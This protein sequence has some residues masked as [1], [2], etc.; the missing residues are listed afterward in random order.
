MNELAKEDLEQLYPVFR[1]QTLELLDQMSDDLLAVEA[2]IVD[3]EIV[4]RLRRCA[5]TIKGD[6]ACIGLE[7]MSNVA[8]GAEDYLDGLGGDASKLDKQIVGKLLGLVDVIRGAMSN[9]CPTDLHLDSR[10]EASRWDLESEPGSKSFKQESA[11]GLKA[12]GKRRKR[13]I[14]VDASKVD[15]LLNLA[16]EMMIAR[17][18]L[19]Q[20]RRDVGGNS[21]DDL[22]LRRMGE[23]VDCLGGLI[24]QFQKSALKMRMVPVDTLFRRYGRAMR[25][26]AGELGK[27]VELRYSGE[28]TELDRHLVEMLYEPVLHLLRNAIDHGIEPVNERVRAGKN[29]AGLILMRA[30]HEGEEVV[31]EVSDDGRGIDL[32]GLKR[33]AQASGLLAESNGQD[34]SDEESAKLVFADGVSTADSITVLSGRGIGGAA[35]KSMVDQ[36]RG[37]VTLKTVRGKGT[38]FTLRVPS[39]LAILRSLLFSSGAHLF[40][41]PMAAVR[42]VAKTDEK[43][44]V[45]INGVECYRIHGRLLSLVKVSDKNEFDHVIVVNAGVREYAI[46]TGEVRGVVELVVKPIEGR[47]TQGRPY[48]GAAVLGDGQVVLIQ[49]ARA[50]YERALNKESSKGNYGDEHGG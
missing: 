12:E 7:R 29:P 37:T 33:R 45:I 11:A 46:A 3:N 50:L 10:Y 49:D 39:T 32:A 25:E 26:L 9:E 34:L 35:V 28:K 18:S 4:A 1:D 13:V 48:I 14:R 38:T 24:T 23:S 47:W 41:L 8:H 36:V 44:V 27:R 15:D 2:G 30:F 5:H 21:A 42:E 19:E 22:M 16:G 6:A 40:A 17:S 31:I 20:A 43:A